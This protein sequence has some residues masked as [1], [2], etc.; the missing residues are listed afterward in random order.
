MIKFR[1][2][3]MQFECD[4]A[5]E[6]A[7][8]LKRLQVEEEK[9][10]RRAQRSPMANLIAD[11]AGWDETH[12]S[13]WN[14]TSFWTFL[15][16]LGEPQKRVLTLLV[17]KRRVTDEELREVLQVES[18]MQ[19]AGILSGISK[20]A[21]AHNLP[22]RAIFTIENERK[23]GQVTKTYVVALDFLRIATEMNWLAVE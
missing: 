9:K 20:Q 7:E 23:S 13:P 14:R 8:L 21:G 19:L 10:L 12:T 15:E 22:A 1:F 17:Q 4:T 18:N 2:A 6:A 11:L 16:S 3:D 5:D